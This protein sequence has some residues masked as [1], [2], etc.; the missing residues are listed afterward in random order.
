MQRLKQWLIDGLCG[1]KNRPLKRYL[2]NSRIE[3]I[4]VG[5]RGGLEPRW[6]SIRDYVEAFTFEPDESSCQE[7][8]KLEYIKQIFPVDLGLSEGTCSF[9]V[10]RAPSVSSLLEPDTL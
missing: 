9:N 8:E 7:L 1:W 6:E 10:C 2:H 4:D 3:L 5:A